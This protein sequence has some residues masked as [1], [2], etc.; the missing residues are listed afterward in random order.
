MISDQFRP[1]VLLYSTDYVSDTF[2]KQTNGWWLGTTWRPCD[3]IVMMTCLYI[4]DVSGEL[5]V[6]PGE[7]KRPSLCLYRPAWDRP[8]ARDV[9]RH[10]WVKFRIAIVIIAGIVLCMRP[11]NER[12]CYNVTPSLIGWVHAQND[13]CYRKSMGTTIWAFFQYK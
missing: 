10:G 5:H 8:F 4:S 9:S 12:R 2:Y 1:L 3:V 11:A 13:P 6:V 7:F